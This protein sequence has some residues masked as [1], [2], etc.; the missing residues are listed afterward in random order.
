MDD[1]A[2]ELINRHGGLEPLALL[3]RSK[4]YTE[5]KELL[6]ATVGAV[7]QCALNKNN[8]KK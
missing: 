1:A 2:R 4:P 3:L 8:V 6:G 7:W 5:N